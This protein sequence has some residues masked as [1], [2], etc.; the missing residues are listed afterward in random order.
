MNNTSKTESQ[1]LPGLV[2]FRKL[3][4]DAVKPKREREIE[5]EREKVSLFLHLLKK[6][7]V[8]AFTIAVLE[9]CF[10]AGAVFE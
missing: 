4:S 9:C 5:R 8:V 1:Y 10:F 6:D 3:Q 7:A 2:V